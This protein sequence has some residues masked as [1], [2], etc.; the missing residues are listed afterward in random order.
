MEVNNLYISPSLYIYIY[1]Y[2]YMKF[3]SFP[4]VLHSGFDKGR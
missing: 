2:I 1:I 3:L 4:N